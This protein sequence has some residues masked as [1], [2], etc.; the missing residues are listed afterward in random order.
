MI[1]VGNGL[2]DFH[3]NSSVTVH[4][5]ETLMHGCAAVTATKGAPNPTKSRLGTGTGGRQGGGTP[6]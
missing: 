5:F 6:L 4:H 2:D 3:V 1:Q